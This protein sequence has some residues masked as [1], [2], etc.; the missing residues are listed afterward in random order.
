MK[1]LE[2]FQNFEIISENLKYHLEKKISLT[3]NIFRPGSSAYF[4]LLK[5][6]RQLFDSGYQLKLNENDKYLF[7]TTDIGRFDYYN[8]DLVPL[9]VP[10]LNETNQP[11]FSIHDIKEG[12]FTEVDGKKVKV[13]KHLS[14]TK[15]KE[16]SCISFEGEVD[17]KPCKCKYDDSKDAYV[18]EAKYH[19]KEVDLNKPM[20]SSGP[21]KYKV[22]VKDPKSGNVRVVN[23]GDAKGGLSAKVSDAKARAAFAARHQCSTK[24]DKTKPGY[25]ACRANRYASL[26]GGKTYPGYW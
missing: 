4:D 2:K 10:I 11:T 26:W 7:E 25:W 16:A 8:G 23:F 14:W 15:N 19:G 12:D 17:G 6:S 3:D 5:E 13:T 9:D 20:R 22:Y 24:K 1:H 21:K 18:F